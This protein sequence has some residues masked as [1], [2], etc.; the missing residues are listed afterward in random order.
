MLSAD[1]LLA[2]FD[3]I[4]VF[5]RGERR[6]VHKPLLILYAVA[7]VARGEPR[8]VDF[9]EL[10][11]PFKALL[12]QFAPSSAGASRHYPFWHLATDGGGAI[13]QLEGPVNIL[14]RPPAGT[15]NLTELRNAHVQGG[16]VPDVDEALRIDPRLRARLVARVLEAHFPATLH[17]DILDALGLPTIEEVEAGEAESRRRDRAFR[18]KVLRAYEYQCCVCR[19]DLRIGRTVAGLEAA[20]IQW[21]QACGPDTE[22]N[23]L[24][25]CS[26]HHKVFDLGGFTVMPGSF[27]LAVS[28]EA[29]MSEATKPLLL[30][31]H[32][33]G[34]ALPQSTTYYPDAKYLAWHAT[35]VFKRPARD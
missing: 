35:S 31:F 12:E 25:L 8:M 29:I 5:Q 30:G 18:E 3:S 15:P 32:G 7:R 13:W 4:R 9:A 22:S 2:R 1:Q 21:F 28:Q 17:G 6:A 34:I 23:G 33:A 19:F 26:L 11:G 20:H 10:E 24:A 27:T 14:D 16:F